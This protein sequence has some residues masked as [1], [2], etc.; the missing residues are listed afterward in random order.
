VDQGRHGPG[1]DR[2]VK[3]PEIAEIEIHGIAAGGAGVGHLPDGRAV[4][5]HRTAPGDRAQVAVTTER[6]RWARG[7]L[8]NLVSAGEG[9]RAPPC[10]LYDRCGGCTLQHLTYE[11]QLRWKARLVEEA[12]S[13]IGGCTVPVAAAVASPR[14]T[15]YRTRVSFTLRRLRNGRVVAG[16]HELDAPRRVLDV[17]REC[18]LPVERLADA[19]AQLR[20]S[21]GSRAARLPDGGELRLTLRTSGQGVVLVIRGGKGSGDPEDLL[22]DVPGLVS[23]WHSPGKGPPVLLAG[24]GDTTESWLGESYRV[25]SSAFLQVNTE[26]GEALHRRVLERSAELP[27]TVVDAYCGVGVFG[28]HLA[29]LGRRATGIEI[30]PEAAGAAREGAAEGFMVLEGKVEERLRETLPAGLVILNPPR[31]GLSAS[32]PD[33]LLATPP[34]A[35]I[36]VSCD[37]ATLARDVARLASGFE[38]KSVEA[39]DLFPQTAHVEAIAVLTHTGAPPGDAA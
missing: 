24:Q 6:A 39:F 17:R 25:A 12:L 31:T 32:V 19:W 18:L 3:S 29:E 21:W 33:V 13:R 26:A 34:E 23:I 1:R 36:Y 38:L 27:G 16:L 9:R 7:R 22:Q 5:V 35:L 2:V 10:P 28:R 14:E 4:F 8:E 15:R 37:P 11:A 30:D 20:G